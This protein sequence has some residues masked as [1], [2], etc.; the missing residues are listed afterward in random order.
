MNEISEIAHKVSFKV[1][2]DSQ[3]LRY[4]A[5]FL[6][7][8]MFEVNVILKRMLLSDSE[9]D[10]IPLIKDGI[11][12]LQEGC[13]KLIGYNIVR[14]GQNNDSLIKKSL[15]YKIHEKV[16]ND[17]PDVYDGFEKIINEFR[18]K[19]VDHNI[20]DIRSELTHYQKDGGNFNP[21]SFTNTALAMTCDEVFDL[22]FD[23]HRFLKLLVQYVNALMHMGYR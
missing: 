15:L 23:Y 3:N 14:S 18:N 19:I 9:T 8:Q 2:D 22:L 6:G 4:I 5:H 21:F 17:K 1:D 10:D 12:V 11:L 7:I 13:K 20:K 16:K